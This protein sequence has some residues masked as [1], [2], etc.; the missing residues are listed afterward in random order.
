MNK[1]Q[2]DQA[3]QEVNG[4]VKPVG[5]SAIKFL[6]TDWMDPGSTASKMVGT[7]YLPSVPGQELMGCIASR[8]LH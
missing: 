2:F 5:L 6:Y 4:P 3:V 8:R 1:V 7:E